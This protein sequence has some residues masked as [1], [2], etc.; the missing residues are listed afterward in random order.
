MPEGLSHQMQW[1]IDLADRVLDLLLEADK[2]GMDYVRVIMPGACKVTDNQEEQIE[3]LSDDIGWDAEVGDS[4][5]II[6]IR[7]NGVPPCSIRNK[8]VYDPYK[9]KEEQ[10]AID[11]SDNMLAMSWWKI[12]I[13]R[14][15][16]WCKGY[17]GA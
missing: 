4:R 13:T 12:I 5:K 8:P 15:A 11:A 2:R 14:F 16:M 3:D 9:V 7:R 10:P 6:N 17:R 1:S